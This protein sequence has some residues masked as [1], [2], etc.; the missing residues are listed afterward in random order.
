M[1]PVV[2]LIRVRRQYCL[3]FYLRVISATVLQAQ[4][5]YPPAAETIEYRSDS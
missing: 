1:R 3:D 5:L 2:A 4:R